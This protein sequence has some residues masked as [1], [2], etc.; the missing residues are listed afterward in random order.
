MELEAGVA[1]QPALD[2][3]AL[4]DGGV[5][6]YDVHVEALGGLLLSMRFKNFLNS[7][8]RCRAVIAE[9]ALPVAASSAA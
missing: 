6:Q 8:D 3:G 7:S 1:H 4:V 9:M 5:V 2:H